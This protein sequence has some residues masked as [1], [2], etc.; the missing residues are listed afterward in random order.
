VLAHA[1]PERLDKPSEED[2]MTASPFEQI[3]ALDY[4]IIFV[5]DMAAMRR[6]YGEVLQFPLERELSQGWIEYRVGSNILAL[7]NRSRT[8]NDP[9]IPKGAA[10]L[11]LAFRV[12]PGTVDECAAAFEAADIAIVESSK[13]QT[14]GHRTLFV[15]DPDGN[16]VEI[17]AEI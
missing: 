15:R 12:P 4:T 10:A 8:A 7:A 17:Y 11:Q 2:P 3:R 9:A 16:L 5:R 1:S 13:D 6:F 14:W